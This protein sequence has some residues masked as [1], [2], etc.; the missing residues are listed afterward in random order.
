MVLLTVSSSGCKKGEQGTATAPGG[1]E[2]YTV[3]A[4]P[5]EKLNLDE[6]KSVE[7]K[8]DRKKGFDDEV[9]VEVTGLPEKVKAEPDKGTIGKDKTSFK[10]ELVVAKDAAAVDNHAVT[11]KSSGGGASKDVN[12]KLTINKK[13]T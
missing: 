12:F 6:K 7:V 4:P 9:K 8:I 13:K 11:I 1:E 5:D 10:F 3:T 2:K